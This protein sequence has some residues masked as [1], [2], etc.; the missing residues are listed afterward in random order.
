MKS[1]VAVDEKWGIGKNNGLLFDIKADMRHFVADPCFDT[2]RRRSGNLS[3]HQPRVES[4]S[5]DPG[6]MVRAGTV[7]HLEYNRPVD[8][9]ANEEGTYLPFYDK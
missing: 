7:I 4:M 5:V 1:I 3:L 9:Y 2:F 6:T 8:E